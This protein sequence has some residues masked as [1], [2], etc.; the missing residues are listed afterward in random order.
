MPRTSAERSAEGGAR[1]PRGE[2]VAVVNGL[3][4]LAIAGVLWDHIVVGRLAP[5]SCRLFLFG[6][7]I[8]LT[9]FIFNGWTGV[10]LFFILSGFVLF[11]PYSADAGRLGRSEDR[12]FFYRRRAMRLLP[13]F[14]IAVISEWIVTSL[15]RYPPTSFA[16]FASVLSFGFI[17]DPQTFG[18][19][20]N[21]ALW[22]IGDEIAFSALFPLLVLGL[23]RIGAG[24]FIVLVLVAALAVRLAGIMRFPA[25][26]AGSFNSDAFPC[27]I[28]EF[29][30]GIVLAQ[31][32]RQGRLP[33]RPG[34]YAAA[35]IV[36]VLASW[37]G[38]D[39][40][41]R[42]ILPP[43]TRAVL[44]NLLDA[45]LCAILVAALV[46]GTRLAAA[47]SWRPLQVVGM[48]CY[49][50]YIWHL[51]LLNWLMPERSLVPTGEFLFLIAVFLAAAF[52][53]AALSYRFIEFRR[54]GDWR[55]L[56]LLRP[57][58][59]QRA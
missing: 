26:Q 53:L 39:M 11:L 25:V 33:R 17:L 54:V 31:L 3:R 42:G 57:P 40:V 4:G 5:T 2:R 6:K 34:L 20:F 59:L 1:R 48:M 32:Y 23:R 46:P 58:R 55:S 30:L 16:E 18:P 13:L 36:L 38:F 45:G 56:F 12:L 8:P 21:V 41:L 27:R 52:A 22:S 51:P 10:N 35:G 50:L 47:L 15:L 49:S 29:V 7:P 37:V 44:N 19:S 24:R 43:I 14:Y 9:A 28:D